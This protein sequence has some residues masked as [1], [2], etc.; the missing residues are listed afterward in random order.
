[1]LL[2]V[3]TPILLSRYDSVWNDEE[4]DEEVAAAEILESAVRIG[5]GAM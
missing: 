2:L 5:S 3:H 4:E 1:M